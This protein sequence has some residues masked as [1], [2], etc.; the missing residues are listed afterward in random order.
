MCGSYHIKFKKDDLIKDYSISHQAIATFKSDRTIRPTKS[1][2]AYVIAE[3][4]QKERHLGELLWGYSYNGKLQANIRSESVWDKFKQ[5]LATKRLVIPASSF[6]EYSK[7]KEALIEFSTKDDSTLSLA[8]IYF[9]DTE[10]K[11]TRFAILTR[12]AQACV[13]EYYHREPVY[14]APQQI[15]TWLNKASSLNHIHD[16]LSDAALADLPAL[17][18]S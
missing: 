5:S 7:E 15:D 1:K 4:K 11:Q 12:A 13:S 3:N 17:K 6:Y 14:L 8:G 2:M 9:T 16:F 18:R 10:L